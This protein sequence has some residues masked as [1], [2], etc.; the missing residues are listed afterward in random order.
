[1][2]ST[3]ELVTTA[4]TVS[5]LLPGRHSK[6]QGNEH[7]STLGGHSRGPVFAEFPVDPAACTTELGR[8]LAETVCTTRGDDDFS[9]LSLTLRVTEEDLHVREAFE[10]FGRHSICTQADFDR[11]QAQMQAWL[12]ERKNTVKVF[13]GHCFKQRI[14]DYRWPTFGGGTSADSSTP[15]SYFDMC[16]GHIQTLRPVSGRHVASGAQV[17]ASMGFT[18]Q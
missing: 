13:G 14:F 2:K 3:V 8:W 18:H 15:E 9:R 11:F 5:R 4:A 10:R 16:A 6:H 7:A 12:A 1:M 17:P